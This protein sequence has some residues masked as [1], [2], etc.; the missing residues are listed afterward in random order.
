[1]HTVAVIPAW[2]EAASL[3]PLLEEIAALPVG[4]IAAVVVVDAG[5]T[6]GTAAVAR[7]HGA[8]VVPQQRRG[9]GAACNEGFQ[10]AQGLGAT[11]VLFLDG[12]GSD[13][14][15]TIPELLAALAP[16]PP[17]AP[18]VTEAPA[19]AV[20]A[21]LALGVRRA[22]PGQRSPL[23]W[24]AR[25]GNV[26]VCALL[27]WRTGRSV[28]DLPSMKALSVERL[29]SLSLSEMGYGWTTELIARALRRGYCVQEVPV[30]TRQRT[31]GV[32]KVSGNW[33]ASM[34]A[35]AALL[36]TALRATR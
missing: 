34:R 28:S 20:Q 6:D 11:H 5:S 29:A 8:Q 18:T 14:P 24:H 22:A 23:P 36:R 30:I 16:V 2:N 35:G 27:R 19:T 9:Y 3:G 12:D 4:T 17:A 13:P 31:G 33:R 1:M 32:S 10:A 26:L 15:A 21:D 25:A 7:A